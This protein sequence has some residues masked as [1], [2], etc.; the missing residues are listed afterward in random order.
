[1]AVAVL[2]GFTDDI[3]L[4]PSTVV[5]IEFNPTSYTVNEDDGTV[6]LIVQ[7]TGQNEIPVTVDISTST[8]SAGGM[9]LSFFLL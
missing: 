7:K 2:Q 5:E 9:H 8:G 6:I 3:I 1:M 4:L